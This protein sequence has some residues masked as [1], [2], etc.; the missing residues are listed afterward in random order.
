MKAPPKAHVDTSEVVLE[1]YT[2]S[3]YDYVQL[4]LTGVTQEGVNS[5]QR[6]FR[7][8]GKRNDFSNPVRLI[9]RAENIY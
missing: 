5:K 7:L 6:Y 2:C 1:G 4:E 3:V 9:K 8:L